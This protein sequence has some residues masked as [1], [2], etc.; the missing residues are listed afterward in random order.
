ME[1]RTKIFLTAILLILTLL[2]YQ[3]SSMIIEGSDGINHSMALVDCSND[4]E[5][6]KIKDSVKK[7]QESKFKEG[8][9]YFASLFLL[10]IFIFL[11]LIYVYMYS[12]HKFSLLSSSVFVIML[13]ITLF[14]EY[15]ALSAL[16]IENGVVKPARGIALDALLV[17]ILIGMYLS[18]KKVLAKIPQMAPRQ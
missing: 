12:T 8:T 3:N 14:S 1:Q 15:F 9:L 13:F 17:L 18:R 5:F 4:F 16:N 10:T 11:Y 2:K 7:I 6:G